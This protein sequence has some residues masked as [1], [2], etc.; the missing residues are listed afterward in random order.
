MPGNALMA[1]LDAV[2]TNTAIT[3]LGIDGASISPDAEI[4]ISAVRW[5]LLTWRL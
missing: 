2:Q 4:V 3:L 1:L 5:V